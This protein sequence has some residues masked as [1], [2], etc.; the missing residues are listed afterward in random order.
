MK[1][2]K[3]VGRA[4][5]KPRPDATENAAP[6]QKLNLGCG[7]LIVAIALLALLA[8]LLPHEPRR[9]AAPARQATAPQPAAKPK[10]GAEA[11][12][13][14]PRRV[15][16]TN[17]KPVEPAKKPLAAQ[18]VKSNT[19][20]APDKPAPRTGA[21]VFND[22]WTGSV[23]QVERYLKRTLHDAASFEA[24]EW[25]PVAETGQGYRVR[26]TYR[27][28]NLLGVYATQTRTFL[29]NRNGEVVAVKDKG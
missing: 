3:P 28:K 7:T 9:P 17:T 29:L 23:S 6:P 11:P 5:A 12:K 16:A 26:C 25:G 14:D 19:P 2:E 1:S 8:K 15:A 4:G 13:E 22:P 21:V 24:L 18:P 27:A 20:K 10:T